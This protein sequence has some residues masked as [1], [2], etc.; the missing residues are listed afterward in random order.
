VN[1]S[2]PSALDGIRTHRRHDH[3]HTMKRKT[4]Y[5]DLNASQP[6]TNDKNANRRNTPPWSLAFPWGKVSICYDV[7]WRPILTVGSGLKYKAAV[8]MEPRI[9]TTIETHEAGGTYVGGR[10]DMASPF[11]MPEASMAP[12]SQTITT[13]FMPLNTFLWRFAQ[14]AGTF[15]SNRYATR[16]MAI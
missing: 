3:H 4:K 8:Q 13:S 5:R 15:F 10:W 2:M 14:P 11:V 9:S 16:S 7:A 12:K 1:L 6:N